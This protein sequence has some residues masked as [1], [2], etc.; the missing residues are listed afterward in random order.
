VPTATSK[1][2]RKDLTVPLSAA[3]REELHEVAEELDLRDAQFVRH[4]IRDALAKHKKDP[5]AR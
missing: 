5:A 1:N 4:L 2:G 3:M